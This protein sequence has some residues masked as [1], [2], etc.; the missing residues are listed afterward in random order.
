MSLNL[1]KKNC[2]VL[3]FKGKDRIDFLNRMSA[4]DLTSLPPQHYKKTVLTTDKGRII[5]L[6]TILNYSDHSIV[7]TTEN[8][9]QR[10]TEHLDKYIIMDDVFIERP[11]KKYSS[12]IVWGED[13]ACKINELESITL[14]GDNFFEKEDNIIFADD[15]GYEKVIYLTGEDKADNIKEKFQ[16]SAEFSFNEY[17]NFRISLGIAEGENEFND[18]INPKECGLERY[19]SYTKGCYIGQEVIARLDAQGKI[20]KQMVKLVSDSALTKDGKIYL[21]GKEVGVITSVSGNIGLGFIRSIAID[22]SKEYES[23]G[24][25]IKI[26]KILFN[27]EILN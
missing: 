19:I 2:G 27:E 24:C 6:I 20:P 12:L 5:D 9:E 10:I 26:E 22:T 15:F 23:E 3:I 7:L 18:L 25:K 14:S 11:E 4:N 16:G 21:D 1:Y 17:E 13:I 8:Y